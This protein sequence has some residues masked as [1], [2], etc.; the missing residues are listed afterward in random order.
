MAC[1][2]RLDWLVESGWPGKERELNTLDLLDIAV[3]IVPDRTAVAYGSSGDR[4][5]TFAQLNERA[6]KL[7][8][9]LSALGV[10]SGGRVMLMDVNGPA[11]PEVY[12]ACV[13]LDAVFVP[14]NYRARAHEVAHLVSEVGPKLVVAGARYSTLV[15]E[16]LKIAKSGAA[17][18]STEM[19]DSESRSV[20]DVIRDASPRETGP[21]KSDEDATMVMFT[22]GTS[23]R[24]KGV[25]LSH[26]SFC[27]FVMANVDPADPDERAAERTLLS[28]PL[29]H[30]AGQ[31]ALMSGIYGGRTTVLQPQFEPESWLILAERQRVTRTMLVPTMLKS[32][33]ECESFGRRDLSSLKIVTYGAA[34]MPERVLLQAIERMP[35]VQF[36]NAFGQTETAATITMLSPEDHD[37]TGPP[38]VVSEKRRR[39]RSIGRPLPDVEVRIVNE[40]GEPVADGV[41][42][43]IV[44]RGPRIM[45]GYWN[46]P[47]A[48]TAALHSG[49][50]HTGDLGWRDQAG[51][52][53]LAG[54]AR[55]F[56]KRGGEMIAPEEVEEVLEQH[57]EVSEAAVIGLPDETWGECVHA[58][59]VTRPGSTVAEDALIEHCRRQLAS[60]KKPERV[61]FVDA[62]PRNQ[63]GK[64]LKGE[65]RA[66]FH[67]GSAPGPRY[68]S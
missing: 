62:L 26:A 20:E 63:L 24:P 22:S 15:A 9:G 54:R 66:R 44:A 34:A 35:G 48:S 43:E 23:S 33:I 60:F 4:E 47:E 21:R 16:A 11:Y 29:Y 1:G 46:Q 8:S 2:K 5:L 57:P 31:Q 52:I 10:G 42:G 19:A 45:K 58:V 68:K 50:L 14:I 55:E 53:F 30:I 36:I 61:H 25:V 12:F 32:L 64:V 51:Y 3:A 40:L 13:W 18:L 7:A 41:V 17:M 59:V 6:A 65:L 37:L 39:L 56:I 27:G 49:W 38:E 28:V 67:P